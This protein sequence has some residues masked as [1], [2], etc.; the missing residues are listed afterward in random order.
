[1]NHDH[2]PQMP[3][4]GSGKLRALLASLHENDSKLDDHPLY[5]EGW[6]DGYLAAQAHHR[7]LTT[8]LSKLYNIEM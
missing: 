3:Q 6:D 4:G 8:A 1:M 5:K 2:F 7:L